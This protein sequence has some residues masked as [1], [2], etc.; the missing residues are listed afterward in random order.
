MSDTAI[1][2]RP[3]M[4]PGPFGAPDAFEHAQRV[5]KALCES[6]MVPEHVR[7]IGAVLV[8]IHIA[9]THGED[10]FAVLQ[11]LQVVKGKVGFSGTY[12]KSRIDRSGLIRGLLQLEVT[13]SGDSLT[14]TA[15]G[16]EVATGHTHEITVSM[17]M[18]KADG[19]TANPKYRSIPEIMLRNRAIAFFQRYV[20][21]S[22]MYGY[23][24]AG[25][26]EDIEHMDARPGLPDY[27]QTDELVGDR[28]T[29]RERPKVP[30]GK[31]ADPPKVDAR[32]D[33]TAEGDGL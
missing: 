19:W 25:E 15:R 26:L 20:C 6:G 1:V 32:T 8:A 14:V 4:M 7:N 27:G 31:P 24:E 18:A 10:L 33:E 2:T 11:A 23:M 5:A 9:A 13:G 17:A 16:V 21:P 29:A 30:R 22:V 28:T 3:P 12:I